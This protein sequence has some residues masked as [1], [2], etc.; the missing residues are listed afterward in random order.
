MRAMILAAGLG[1]RMRPLTLTIPK[2][3]LEAGGKPLIHYHLEHLRK[4]GFN[5]VVVNHA[6]LGQQ[7]ENALQDGRA[8][9]LR[10]RYSPES[11]P[12]E[13]AGGI[14]QAL[15]LLTESGEDWFLVIN[16]DVW[17]DFELTRLSPPEDGTLA[18]L[19]L[20]DNPEHHPDGDFALRDDGRMEA[21][22]ADRK[23]FSGISLLHRS[24]FDDL[25][26]GVHR[27]APILRDAMAKG[28]VRGLYHDGHWFD[29][30]T[31]ARLA[32]LDQRLR[33]GL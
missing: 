8:W 28:Q 14:R 16:S 10:I 30:G 23:T 7:I 4:A 25:A 29:I 21:E 20:V 24:L 26:P 2:P 33:Q 17:C 11:E 15:P 5:E 32:D 22:G 13:T 9:G 27:L 1:T 31:P 18:L 3:L 12:L 6:W 19:V